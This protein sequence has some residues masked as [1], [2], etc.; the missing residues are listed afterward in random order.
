LIKSNCI[1]LYRIP[2]FQ[3]FQCSNYRPFYFLT[4]KCLAVFHR[5]LNVIVTLRYIVI[6]SPYIV[7][8]FYHPFFI[9][10]VYRSFP[11][12]SLHTSVPAAET[13]GCI[14]YYRNL[15][16][17]LECGVTVIAAHCATPVFPLINKKIIRDFYLFMKS[18]TQI[19]YGCGQIPLRS[20][21]QQGCR[22][23]PK[24]SKPFHLIG[25]CTALTSLSPSTAGRIFPRLPMILHQ[26]NI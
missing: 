9:L 15:E 23:Y 24:S 20:P 17:P 16:R 25:L 10:S 14:N 12:I 8:K 6:P 13:A 22:S 2:L 3:S 19:V 26:R 18:V 5:Y 4:Q 21:Y 7:V 1:D 11:P